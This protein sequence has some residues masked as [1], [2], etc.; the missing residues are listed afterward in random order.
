MGRS[1]RASGATQDW[2][3]NLFAD[4]A[5]RS[6]PGSRGWAGAPALE[7]ASVHSGKQA[8]EE[9]LLEAAGYSLTR[10]GHSGLCGMDGAGH[11]AHDPQLYLGSRWHKLP[12]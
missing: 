3:F 12:S 6:L 8:L 4:G 2:G 5:G 11:P 10:T 7:L 1:C 9:G